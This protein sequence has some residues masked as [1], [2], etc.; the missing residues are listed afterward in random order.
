MGAKST[1]SSLGMF[2]ECYTTGVEERDGSQ[3]G[4]RSSPQHRT[5]HVGGIWY[6][7]EWFVDDTSLGSPRTNKAPPNALTV[8]GSQQVECRIQ[9][10]R[11]VNLGRGAGGLLRLC[12][13]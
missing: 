11:L 10:W 3:L 4:A 13:Y 1:V 9:S 8:S 5:W 6:M 2:A 7:S 12:R